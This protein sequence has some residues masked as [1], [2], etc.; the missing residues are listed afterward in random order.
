MQAFGNTLGDTGRFQSLVD[1]VHTV[2][3]LDGLAGY[4]VPLGRTPG[5]GRNASLAADTKFIVHKDNA[6]LGPFLHGPRRAGS[7]TPG[8]LAV[9]AGHKYIGHAREIVDLFGTHR[10]DLGQPGSDGQIVFGFAMGLA[11]ETSDTAFGVL[12]YVVFAHV[13]SSSL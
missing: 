12:V 10:D 5:A 4:R 9:E 11:A 1:P 13:F 7:H 6:V 8:V 2:I 3:T